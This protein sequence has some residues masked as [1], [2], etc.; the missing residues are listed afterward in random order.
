VH[1]RRKFCA[2]S[3]QRC[4]LTFCFAEGQVHEWSESSSSRGFRSIATVDAAYHN[5]QTV[6]DDVRLCSLRCESGTQ[7]EL[8]FSSFVAQDAFI[9][10][11]TLPLPPSSLEDVRGNALGTLRKSAAA[12]FTSSTLSNVQFTFLAN[13]SSAETRVIEANKEILRSRCSYFESSALLF[14]LFFPPN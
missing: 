14:S 3:S 10:R 13:A 6:M 1:A 12:M 5:R 9:V 7:A 2:D 4:C 8:T 11:C